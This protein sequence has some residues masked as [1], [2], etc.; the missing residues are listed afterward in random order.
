MKNLKILSVVSVGIILCLTACEKGPL[1]F[2]TFEKVIEN[3]GSFSD[4][5][6][7]EMSNE[8]ATID[9]IIGGDTWVC[10]TETKDLMAPGGGSSGFPLFSPNAGII[11]PGGLLQGKSLGEASPDPIAVKRAPGTI[12]TDI[13]DGNEF[14]SIT[15]DEVSKSSVTQAINDI[16]R[17]S[18]G[19]VPANFSFNYKSIQSR[20]EFAMELG[21]DVE[22]AFVEI[23][24]KLNLNFSEN[25]NRYYVKLEQSFYTMSFDMPRN[26]DDVFAPSV[27]P[28]DLAKY[29]QSGNPACYI[30][31]VTYGR[32]FYMTIESTSSKSEMDLA[33]SGSYN[34]VGVEVDGDLAVEKMKK[35][36][37]LNISVFAFGGDSDESFDAIGLTNINDLKEVLGKGADIRSGKALS[38]VVKSVYD[39]KVVA[40]QLATKYDVTNCIPAVD[41]DAPTISR[42]WAGVS[43]KMG[44]VGAAFT[45]KDT[46]IYLI[47]A[48]GDEYMISDVGTLEGPFPI[49]N[50]GVGTMPFDKIGA[51]CNLD[52]NQWDT[53]TIMI[54]DDTGTKYSYL[55]SGAGSDWRSANSIFE[56]HDGQCPFNSAGVGALIFNHKDPLG[57]SSRYFYNSAGDKYTLYNNN[58]QS[59]GGVYPIANYTN[60]FPSIGAGIGIRLG[61]DR[62][63]FYFDKEKAQYSVW[64]NHDGTGNK[65]IGPFNY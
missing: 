42:H 55:L 4:P 41:N 37:N 31:D 44:L 9:S 53:P 51:A 30:S 24:S 28:Q 49:Q 36:K 57:P 39:N 61:N 46:E 12:S 10:T 13:V 33:I 34:G 38:Y 7:S 5:V 15:V 1:N 63:E 32:I 26:Y 56:M 58:P 23:E 22:T 65:T 16:I 60:G 20:E 8:A 18:T 35:L 11:F 45:G 59:W 48:T 40:T 14:A 6:T 27:T 2:K 52:G 25:I 21:V 29:V 47:S 62:F 54:F 64:G 50:L 17:N 43:S 3:G 19:V